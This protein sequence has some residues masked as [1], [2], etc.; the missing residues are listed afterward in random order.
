VLVQLSSSAAQEIVAS[1]AFEALQLE[2]SVLTYDGVV[3]VMAMLALG[4]GG[5][6]KKCFVG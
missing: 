3:A 4:G 1:K 2:V 5:Y 6:N